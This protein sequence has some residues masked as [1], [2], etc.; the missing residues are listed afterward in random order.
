MATPKSPIYVNK[1]A[2]RRLKQ[3]ENNLPSKIYQ[4]SWKRNGILQRTP[5]QNYKYVQ[6]NL[7]NPHAMPS[8]L[9][10]GFGG[11]KHGSLAPKTRKKGGK[12]NKKYKT[13]RK[14]RR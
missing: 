6:S 7:E 2:A 5:L 8:E 10:P 11:L 13:T 1:N 14:S 12:R 3:L 9:P 4:L